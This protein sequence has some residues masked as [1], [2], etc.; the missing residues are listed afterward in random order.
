MTLG[1]MAITGG[2]GPPVTGSIPVGSAK[3]LS[4]SGSTTAS[5]A[6]DIGSIPVRADYFDEN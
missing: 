4:Y 3:A 2:F 6:V 5:G 1:V